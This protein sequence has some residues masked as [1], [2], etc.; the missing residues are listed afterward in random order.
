MTP[1]STKE[2]VELLGSDI[3]FIKLGNPMLRHRG[4][5]AMFGHVYFAVLAAMLVLAAAVYLLIRRRMAERGNM[6]LVR[7]KRANKVAVQRF[8]MAERYM[9]ADD[10]HAFYEEMLKA[11]WGYMGD[12]FNIPTSNL[13]KEIVRDELRKRGVAESAAAEFTDIISRCDEAQ[14]SPVSSSQM[15]EVYVRGINIVSDIEATIKK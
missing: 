13:S 15:N 7:G 11:L 6:A 1:A 5:P 9:K 14:Y 4:E 12:K 3:R 10:R 8:R 2:D